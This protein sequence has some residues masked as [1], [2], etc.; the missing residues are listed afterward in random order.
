MDAT[1]GKVSKV[2]LL[3][4]DVTINFKQD[5]NGLTIIPSKKS[6]ALPGIHNDSLAAEIR[7]FKITHDKG[8]FNDDDPGATYPGWM[9]RS[10][11]GTGDYNND[12]TISDTPGDVWTSSFTGKSISVIAPKED[13]RGKDGN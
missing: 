5:E 1:I 3:G 13:R 2:E 11:L 6:T 8:W 9:R 7:V 4:S 12:L 10:N